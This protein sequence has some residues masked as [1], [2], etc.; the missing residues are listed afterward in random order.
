MIS[1][2]YG[3][4]R[5]AAILKSQRM[6]YSG[7]SR[8]VCDMSMYGLLKEAAILKSQRMAYSGASRPVCDISNVRLT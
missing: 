5:E 3:L 1:Q 2:M 7:A 8:P 4:L 6:A